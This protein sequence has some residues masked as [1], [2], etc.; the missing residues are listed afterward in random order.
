VVAVDVEQKVALAHPLFT[1]EG[2]SFHVPTRQ[3]IQNLNL[4]LEQGRI[5]GLIG[6]NG[7]GKSTLIKMLARQQKPSAGSIS[8][9]GRPIETLSQ[10]GLAQELA[11]L[12]QFMPA[13]D[14]MNVEEFVALGRFPWHGTFGRFT[15][16]DQAKV[17]E[18]LRQT[19]VEPFRSRLVDSLSGGERQRVWLAMLLAQDPACLILD[20]PTSA[21]DI[22]H[23]A[24]MLDLVKTLARLH[25]WSVVIVLHDINMAA[26]ICDRMVALGSGQIIADG[27][28]DEIMRPDILQRIYGIVMKVIRDTD[29]AL[30]V[31]YVK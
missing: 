28:P 20:E 8:F 11:Y 2:V 13:T 1:L 24:A 21:L 25:S 26:R 23:Q 18:A 4:T 30:P 12:P 15:A 16:Q 6:P 5:H 17:D 14:G 19:D 29:S 7:S 31:A 27:T 22:S 9:S 3:I 10:R